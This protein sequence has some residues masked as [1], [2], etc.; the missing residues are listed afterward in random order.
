MITT[1]NLL[2]KTSVAKEYGENVS[3]I[4]VNNST[5]KTGENLGPFVT[6]NIF[7]HIKQ[8]RIYRSYNS[9]SRCRIIKLDY[10]SVKIESFKIEKF[11]YIELLYICIILLAL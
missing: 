4:T 9:K 8:L 6:E 7:E 3:Q 2:N 1:G 5:N 10:F 11:K